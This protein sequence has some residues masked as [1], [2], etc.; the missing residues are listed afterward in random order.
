MFA[1]LKR[2]YCVFFVELVWRGNVYRI[3]IIA[4]QKCLST[5]MCFQLV[6]PGKVSS[7]SRID[8]RGSS[9]HHSGVNRDCRK[10]TGTRSPQA[11]DAD[12]Q[13]VV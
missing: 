5:F 6:I 13:L 11:N 4:S 1:M 7:Q 2:E 10:H 12:A 8:F 9:K 3:N